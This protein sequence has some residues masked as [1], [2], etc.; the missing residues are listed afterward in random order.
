MLPY[1]ILFHTIRY[2]NNRSPLG[3]FD[4]AFDNS[5]NTCSTKLIYTGRRGIE[6]KIYDVKFFNYGFG[7]IISNY[8]ETIVHNYSEYSFPSIIRLDKWFPRNSNYKIRN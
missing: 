1:C 4:V 2:S 8:I 3:I 5:E 7:H 6:E